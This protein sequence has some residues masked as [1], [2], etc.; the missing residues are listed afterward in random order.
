MGFEEVEVVVSIAVDDGDA[1]VVVGVV[2]VGGLVEGRGARG[3]D[4]G[5]VEARV[6][7]VG[8]A[9]V[10]HEEHFVVAFRR[11]KNS[12]KLVSEMFALSEWCLMRESSCLRG[13]ARLHTPPPKK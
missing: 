11:S 4:V 6:E 13:N 7:R 3:D 5:G 2:G 1:D 12:E 8:L 10:D 9:G